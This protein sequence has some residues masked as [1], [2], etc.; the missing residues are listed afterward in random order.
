MSV[1]ELEPTAPPGAPETPREIALRWVAD[2]AYLYLVLSDESVPGRELLPEV[3][4]FAPVGPKALKL[5]MENDPRIHR[6]ERRWKVITQV[7]DPRRPIERAIVA[8]IEAAGLPL[9]T[10]A[11]GWQLST[12]YTREESA[13]SDLVARMIKGRPDFF[14]AGEDRVG[15]SE[16]LLDATAD[17]EEDLEFENFEDTTEIDALRP[18]AEGIDWKAGTLQEGAL[19][20]LDLAGK[21]ITTRAL[22]FFM[23]RAKAQRFNPAQQFRFL[24]EQPDAQLISPASWIGPKTFQAAR[25][26]LEEI[27]ESAEVELNNEDVPKPIT[28]EQ[29]DIDAMAEH[30]ATVPLRTPELL[31]IQFPDLR[32]DDP[33]YPTTIGSLDKAIR[34]DERFMWVGWDRWISPQPIPAS[35]KEYSSLL[36]PIVVDIEISAGQQEDVELDDDGL[37]G[38]L[39]QEIQKPLVKYGGTIEKSEDGSIRCL[40]TYGHRQTG[41]LPI[42]EEGTVFPRLPEFLLVT[43]GDDEGH[44]R[45]H[46]VNNQLGL[47]YNLKEWY[48]QVKLP[49]SGGVFKFRPQTGPGHYLLDTSGETDKATYVDENRIKDLRNLRDRALA[50]QTSTREIIQEIMSHHSKGLTFPEL[51]AEVIVARMTSPRM[52][53]SI[54][55][56][57]YEYYPKGNA[58]LFNERDVSKGFK[59]QKKKYVR[60][61]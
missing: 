33:N 41:T 11:M 30:L 25:A 49:Q 28:V 21:P 12:V 7:L 47:I 53:A 51:Y 26:A 61:R 22:Q 10:D 16:W 46:W 58:W 8:L 2:L 6:D 44:V 27:E 38:N 14:D 23:C 18:L 1:A 17:N 45:N 56:S 4:R 52:I 3:N 36:N 35:A 34:S 54:L 42:G 31:S 13:L 29:E 60:R 20:L 9:D 19:Q 59:K 5:A 50:Q 39:A 15:A 32:A 37:E 48:D 43:T 55:S 40:I 57:Y 24:D